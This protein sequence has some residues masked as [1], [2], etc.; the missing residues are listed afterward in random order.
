MN[1]AH[2]DIPSVTELTP[3]KKKRNRDSEELI[4][5][6][7]LTLVQAAR[8]SSFSYW[9]LRDLVLSGRLPRVQFPRSF[10][11]VKVKG[12]SKRNPEK[13][14]HLVR[15]AVNDGASLRAIRIDRA[16]L[17][18]LIDECKTQEVA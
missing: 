14:H 11:A 3:T 1:A 15:V 9:S 17:D 2:L 13:S 12:G 4:T 18:R 7:L 5:P 10:A 16:D 8:Y 6:R